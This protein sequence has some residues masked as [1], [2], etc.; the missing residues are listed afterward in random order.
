MELDATSLYVI[1][2][3]LDLAKEYG[4]APAA[5]DLAR[6]YF[7]RIVARAGRTLGDGRPYLLGKLFSVA[8]ILM[9]SCF[10]FADQYDAP[11][12]V[13]SSFRACTRR[14]PRNL[15]GGAC[16]ALSFPLN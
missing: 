1:R 7:V 4:E 10:D 12:P 13:V 5:V 9:V 16:V 3:H 6:D 11:L 2:R 14:S 8:D 15:E